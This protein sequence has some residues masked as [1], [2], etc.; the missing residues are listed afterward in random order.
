MPNRAGN[1]P[2]G[3]QLAQRGSSGVARGDRLAICPT[4]GEV[5]PADAVSCK[6]CFGDIS[7]KS[8]G[9][10]GQSQLAQLHRLVTRVEVTNK[11]LTFLTFSIWLMFALFVGWTVM[12]G[13]MSV[14][15]PGA[16]FR[17]PF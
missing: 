10:S 14:G 7:G 1:L 11:R 5:N 13:I 9:H 16:L 17:W 2:V 6:S 3:H 4:C 8:G 12:A 15:G